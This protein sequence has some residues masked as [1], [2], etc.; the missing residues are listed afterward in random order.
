MLTLTTLSENSANRKGLLAEHGLSILIE[1][2]NY[3]ILFDTG[4]GISVV[5]N[6]EKMGINLQN[7]NEIALSH[8]HFDHT[9][10]L[11]H[12]LVNGPKNI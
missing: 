10:G 6:A 9:G 3:S 8:G 12:I 1:Y 7:V 2:G 11:K 5:H 4:Q